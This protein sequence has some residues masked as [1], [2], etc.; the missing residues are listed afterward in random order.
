M[1]AK[2]ITAAS[3]YRIYNAGGLRNFGIQGLHW[4]TSSRGKSNPN[5]SNLDFH[6]TNVNPFNNNN[7]SYGFS[8]RCVQALTYLSFEF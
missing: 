7:R 8:V 5:S 3:G 1:I 2:G 4:S 6:G